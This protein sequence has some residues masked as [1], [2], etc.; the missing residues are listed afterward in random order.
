MSTCISCGNP[1]D[2]STNHNKM[3]S[4]CRYA[5]TDPRLK[6]LYPARKR[7]KAKGIPCTLSKEDIVLPTHC[8][9]L[10]M[11]LDYQGGGGAGSTKPNSPSLDRVIPDLG[12]V[13]GNVQVISYRANTMKNA[14][15]IEELTTF[16]ENIH[17]YLM[18]HCLN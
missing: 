18:Q 4:N 10:G 17:T 2:Y 8:P 9:L 7:A 15:T 12:Y 3:C 16:A 13:P 14:A 1:H 5:A 11:E 6:L